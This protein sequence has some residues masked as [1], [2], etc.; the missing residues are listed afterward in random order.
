MCWTRG[1]FLCPCFQDLLN[2]FTT[3][4]GISYEFGQREIDLP[5]LN[6][7]WP[8]GI[9][10]SIG[11]AAVAALAQ[12]MLQKWSLPFFAFFLQRRH[13]FV[14]SRGG[15]GGGGGVY[16]WWLAPPN[17]D[18]KGCPGFVKAGTPVAWGSFC[19]VKPEAVPWLCVFLATITSS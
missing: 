9:W 5:S 17:A 4:G 12:W 3:T 7:S 19:G 18:A 1:I 11:A 14:G 8:F 2:W 10:S 13:A 6:E 15:A 16:G